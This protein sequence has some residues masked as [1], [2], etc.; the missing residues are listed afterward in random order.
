M[1]NVK[2]KGYDDPADQTLEPE[3]GLL[4]VPNLARSISQLADQS[5]A[6]EKVQRKQFENTIKRSAVD[7]NPREEPSQEEGNGNP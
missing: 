2:W 1:L 4:Y 5:I 3:E 6:T 7:Q